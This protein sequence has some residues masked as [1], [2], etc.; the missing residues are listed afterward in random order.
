MIYSPQFWVN[1]SVRRPAILPHI[2]RNTALNQATTASFHIL[3]SS[4]ISFFPLS[5]LGV[6]RRTGVRFLRS[7]DMLR[8]RGLVVGSSQTCLFCFHLLQLTVG[9]NKHR[10]T[11]QSPTG[12]VMHHQFNIQQLYALPTLFM[13]FVFI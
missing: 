1:T 7:S 3:S 10:L 5:T 9:T 11:F 8:Q 6:V 13:C 4:S 2:C 12:H